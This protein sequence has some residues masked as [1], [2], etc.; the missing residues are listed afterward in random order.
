MILGH[1]ERRHVFGEGDELIGQKVRLPMCDLFQ[2]IHR[3]Q[4]QRSFQLHG[5]NKIL[6]FSVAKNISKSF[7]HSNVTL[8]IKI[9][10]ISVY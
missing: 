10:V 5:R 6:L 3:S 8:D 9:L 1:S 7:I 2:S 4:F